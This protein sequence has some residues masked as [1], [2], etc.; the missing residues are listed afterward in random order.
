CRWWQAQLDTAGP[1]SSRVAAA[2]DTASLLAIAH[3]A[4]PR[5]ENTLSW[6]VRARNLQAQLA[7]ARGDLAVARTNLSA[8]RALLEPAWQALQTETLR[9]W[10]AKTRLLEGEAAQLGR[11]TAE[12][13]AAWT[14]ARQVLLA[15]AMT[16]L[17]FARLDPL[18]RALQHLGLTAEAAPHR[19]RLEDAG[20]VPLHPWPVAPAVAAR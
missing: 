10:L 11:N 15:D 5:N 19:Q 17:P 14:E 3:A 13:S 4:D 1:S 8:A 18:V 9:L 20:Y 7:L 2:D 16:P 12:A 6:L